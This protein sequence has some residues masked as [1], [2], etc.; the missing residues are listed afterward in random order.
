M[1]VNHRTHGRSLNGGEAIYKV[2]DAVPGGLQDQGSVLFSYPDGEPN[3]WAHVYPAT[4]ENERKRDTFIKCFAA[5]SEVTVRLATPE[6]R[7]QA[8]R[9]LAEAAASH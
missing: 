6:E 9:A 2:S 3:G 5:S 4:P 8:E 7:A 1:S